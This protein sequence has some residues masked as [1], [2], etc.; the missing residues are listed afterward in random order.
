M[1][2]KIAE[3]RHGT[4]KMSRTWDVNLFGNFDRRLLIFLPEIINSE[5][6]IKCMTQNDVIQP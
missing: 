3:M 4:S 6:D 1:K 2:I 5:L